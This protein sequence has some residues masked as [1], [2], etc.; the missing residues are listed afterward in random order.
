MDIGGGENVVQAMD[1]K[2]SCNCTKIKVRWE[3]V[4]GAN[5]PL[6]NCRK[7]MSCSK[8]SLKLAIFEEVLGMDQCTAFGAALIAHHGFLHPIF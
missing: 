4:K 3:G 7:L 2:R 8:T 6:I 1:T 5:P